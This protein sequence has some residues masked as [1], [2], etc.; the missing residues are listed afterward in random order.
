MQKPKSGVFINDEL[1]DPLGDYVIDYLLSQT[2]ETS[3]HDFKWTIDVRKDSDFPEIVK[4][5]FAFSNHGGGFIVLG[6]KQNDHSDD[7]IKGSFV[8]VGLP[9]DFEIDQAT[10]QEKI[11]AYMDSPL[12]IG[13]AQF[14]RPINKQQR[15]FALIY[16]PPS[17]KILTPTKDGVYKRDNKEK[18]AFLKDKI[19]TRRGT[20][21]IPAL[22]AEIDWIKK[23]LEDENYRLSV[24]SGEPDKIEERLFS[25]LFEVKSLPKE[26]Y[27][28]TAKFS[29][30][31]E[32][33]EFL[34][35]KYPDKRYF[36]LKYRPYEDK[37]ITFQ[38][39]N[40]VNN[41]HH[42]LVY[43]DQIKTEPI[44]SWLDSSDKERIIIALLNKEVAGKGIEQNMRYHEKTKKLYYPTTIDSRIESWPTRYKGVSQ[45]TVAKRMWAEQV[46]H[47]IFIHVAA[48][49]AVIRIKEKFY[50]KLNLSSIITE[51]GRRVSTGMKEG[52]IITR[53]SYNTFN[54]QYLNNILFWINKL[55]DGNDVK[56][57]EDF[58]ISVDPVQTTLDTGIS[59]D[60]PTSEIK[61]FIENYTPEEIVD[62]MDEDFEEETDH[63][64]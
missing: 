41:I 37:I 36:F 54:N 34:H 26:V 61:Y 42:D 24:I 15:K 17:S 43:A 32:T 18:K 12:A 39:L 51:D 3:F 50:L 57:S 23:R 16:I 63:E 40:D 53:S 33:Q 7:K 44:D 2:K 38:N 56:V 14:E 64:S 59:W 20:Q 58:I 4:D 31:F 60:I 9:N 10:L 62:D 35:N 6:V 47:Y 46:K 52:S 48:K 29:S 1:S 5:V 22:E 45:K 28:G 13:Y 49:I 19:Y 21:G 55:G 27:V 11:N 8:K 30:F 25:N